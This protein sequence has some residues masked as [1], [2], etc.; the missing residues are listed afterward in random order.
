MKFQ[1]A[2]RMMMKTINHRFNHLYWYLIP[3]AQRQGMVVIKRQP[4][5]TR[6]EQGGR[7]LQSDTTSQI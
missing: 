1:E 5:P 7:H 6:E 4:L 3:V 2:R